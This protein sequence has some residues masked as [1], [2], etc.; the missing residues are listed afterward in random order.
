M[1]S[2]GFYE[3][4]FFTGDKCIIFGLFWLKCEFMMLF[5]IVKVQ[6]NAMQPVKPKKKKVDI[7]FQVEAD[8]APCCKRNWSRPACK[9]RI[10]EM[11]ETKIWTYGWMVV[12]THQ[13]Q[14]PLNL[15]HSLG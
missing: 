5:G 15:H 1:L 6:N 11:K 9:A 2:F 10:I 7:H 12:S 3:A 14:P 4:I 13:I 8:Y